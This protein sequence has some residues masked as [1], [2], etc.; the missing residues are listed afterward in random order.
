VA[1]TLNGHYSGADRMSALEHFS[2][3]TLNDLK[4]SKKD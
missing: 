1:A 2:N 3:D 4:E